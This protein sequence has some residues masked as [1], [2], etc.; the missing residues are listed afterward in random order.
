MTCGQKEAVLCILM[1]QRKKIRTRVSRGTLCLPCRW[2]CFHCLCDS[3]WGLLP[4]SAPQF[5]R[6]VTGNLAVPSCARQEGY[7][8]MRERARRGEEEREAGVGAGGAL[9]PPGPDLLAAAAGERRCL[10]EEAGRKRP[11]GLGW[12]GLGGSDP[13]QRPCSSPAPPAAWAALPPACWTRASAL[14]S[15]VGLCKGEAKRPAASGDFFGKRCICRHALWWES[16]QKRTR[17]AAGFRAGQGLGQGAARCRYLPSV[18]GTEPGSG[19]GGVSG[20]WA[21]R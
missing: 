11:A 18:P 20:V 1:S 16:S 8:R 6:L 4:P 14:T 15:E 2:M 3:F 9:P 19:A 7:W 5:T 12:A 10:R 21:H 13:R 17:G